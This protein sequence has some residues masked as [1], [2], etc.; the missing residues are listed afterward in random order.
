MFKNKGEG[1]RS[2]KGFTMIELIIVIA[3]MGILSAILVPSFTE[4]TRKSRL[5]SDVSTIQQVNAQINLYIAEKD[6]L[7]P[8]GTDGATP[9]STAGLT[10]AAVEHL[11]DGG[12]IKLT[13]T[14]ASA[15]GAI[16]LQSKGV[17]VQYDTDKEHLI[18]DVSGADTKIKGSAAK[19][20][21]SDKLWTNS[22]AT[23]TTP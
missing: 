12:Y 4:M 7:F 21:E 17:T 13:D 6:G 9:T 22:S 3:I 11:V 5:R 8:G 14:V 2:E 20:S 23:P 18:L 16:K 10:T 15:K 1:I 19:L